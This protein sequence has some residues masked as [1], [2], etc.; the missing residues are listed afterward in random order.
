MKN[1]FLYVPELNIS[2]LNEPGFYGYSWDNTKDILSKEGLRMPTIEEF[3]IL[4]KYLDEN[5]RKFED[6]IEN[7]ILDLY[8]RISCL[9]GWDGFWLDSLFLKEKDLIYCL[10]NKSKS[11]MEKIFFDFVNVNFEDWI[12]QKQSLTGLPKKYNRYGNMMFWTPQEEC[13]SMYRTGNKL[14][15]HCNRYRRMKDGNVGVIACK[16]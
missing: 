11:R 16:D 13:V 8:K 9:S 14:Y 2:F 1:D 12:F 10:S 7:K 3:R 6:N 5:K 4:L 15:L